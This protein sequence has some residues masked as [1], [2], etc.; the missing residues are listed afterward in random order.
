MC[1]H[2]SRRFLATFATP[3][4]RPALT[5]L[6][7]LRGR[8]V[9]E[10]LVDGLHRAENV[11][12]LGL[13]DDSLAVAHDVRELRAEGRIEVDHGGAFDDGDHADIGERDALTDKEGA[14]GE[15]RLEGLEGPDLALNECV[16]DLK[17]KDSAAGRAVMVER[18]TGLT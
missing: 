9:R 3:N 12:Q 13:V 1:C 15:V 4:A 5:S 6:L 17:T 8:D 16:V 7:F 14:R 2:S 18:P 11:L 10:R